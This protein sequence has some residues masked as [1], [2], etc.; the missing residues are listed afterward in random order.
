ME[1]RIYDN[2]NRKVASLITVALNA[3][4]LAAFTMCLLPP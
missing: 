1:V 2:L 4:V 3:G